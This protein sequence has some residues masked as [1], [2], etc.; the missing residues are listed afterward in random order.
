[1]GIPESFKV[2]WYPPPPPTKK[3]KNW[4][5]SVLLRFEPNWYIRVNLY[6]NDQKC[7]RWRHD[8]SA[9]CSQQKF[10]NELFSLIIYMKHTQDT[11]L[12]IY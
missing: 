1:M 4:V 12:D 11:L 6:A 3:K 8:N 7:K 9:Y 10:F 2:G 5:E